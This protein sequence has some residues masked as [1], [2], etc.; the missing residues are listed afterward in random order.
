[1]PSTSDFPPPRN[2]NDPGAGPAILGITWTVTAFATVAVLL[3]AHLG[4]KRA[5]G[6]VLD[7]WLMFAA[8]ASIFLFI[9]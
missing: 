1:M 7:D 2:P 4:R 8:M 3:R 9:W 5:G 6:L